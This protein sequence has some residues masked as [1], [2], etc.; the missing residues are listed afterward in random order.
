MKTMKKE[1]LM[2]TVVLGAICLAVAV[3]L[4]VLNL[5]TEPVI[6][7]TTKARQAASMS[8]AFPSEYGTLAFTEIT[9]ELHDVPDTVIGVHKETG[10]HG[11]AV[12]IKRSGYTAEGISLTVAISPEGDILGT[13]ITAYAETRDIRDSGLAESFVGKDADTLSDVPLVSGATKS[14]K[15]L[16]AALSDA[17][18]VLS[19]NGLTGGD[20]P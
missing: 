10:G 20:A 12:L 13:V 2:P 11:Y 1:H 9:G 18:K 5:F 8:A 6:E 3:L 16:R 19:D 7:A 17:L 15:A 14:S 4:S